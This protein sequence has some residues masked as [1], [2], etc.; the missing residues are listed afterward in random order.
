MRLKPLLSTSRPLLDWRA[1]VISSGLTT[2][3]LP[4]P[5]LIVRS[6][7]RSP[8]PVKPPPAV[9]IR[10]A[11]TAWAVVEAWV[12]RVRAPLMLPVP[13]TSRLPLSRVRFP[14]KSV[15]LLVSSNSRVEPF[16]SNQESTIFLAAS[17]TAS[18][19]AVP[20]PVISPVPPTPAQL[21]AVVQTSLPLCC[22]VPVKLDNTL[23]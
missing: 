12:P 18:R 19:P 13:V 2:M 21:P 22:K 15:R 3:P 17:K 14:P 16:C 10:S 4:A 20:E 11:L 5:M 1:R 6:T 7:V 8:P 9:S 23:S